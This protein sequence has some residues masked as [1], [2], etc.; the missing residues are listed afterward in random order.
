MLYKVNIAI[1]SKFNCQGFY[2]DSIDKYKLENVEKSDN[3]RLYTDSQ[4]RQILDSD[5][6]YKEELKFM[7][8]MGV[9]VHELCNI[10]VKDIDLIHKTIH[11]IGKGGRPSDR[12]ILPSEMPFMK[13][14]INGKDSYDRVFKVSEN[15]KQARSEI[16]SE[17]RRITK[18]LNIPISSKCHEF[19]KYAA[20]QYFNYLVSIGYSIKKSEEITVSK[21][22]S[23]GAN[24][25]DLK[26]IYLRS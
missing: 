13:S 11:I 25:E 8:V 16:G 19:R 22:L 15:E 12:P 14:L 18:M 23:H 24:R 21:F 9:R 4:I 5:S 2:N 3:K 6:K 7:S 1:Q 17:I 20:Q 26:K 10:R